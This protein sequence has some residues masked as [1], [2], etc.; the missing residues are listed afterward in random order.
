VIINNRN[1]LPVY[2]HRLDA[3]PSELL[4]GPIE[5][6]LL[7]ADQVIAN[8]AKTLAD[9]AIQD[10]T[11]REEIIN[12]RL[13]AALLRTDVD[14]VKAAASELR[15]IQDRGDRKLTMGLVEEIAVDALASHDP[16]ATAT[17]LAKIRLSLL[18]Y[19]TVDAWMK[20]ER[21]TLA[22]ANP[23][24]V[25]GQ[26]RL[27]LDP[28]AEKNGG[29]VDQRSAAAVVS[30]RAARDRLYP[31]APQ[32]AAAL[33][34][35][36]DANSTGSKT[37]IWATRQVTLDESS[38]VK[39]IT[40]AIWDSGVD[41]NLFT[42]AADPG[43]AIDGEGQAVPDLLRPT[44]GYTERLPELLDLVKGL[45]DLRAGQMTSAA[46]AYQSRAAALKPEEVKEFSEAL[47]FVANYVHGTHVAGIAAEGNPFARIQAI[48]MHFP[49]RQEDMKLD[50]TISERRAAFYREAIKRMQA[51]GARVVNMSWR[52]GP[53]IFESILA[54]Q[55]GAADANE[56]KQLAAE[57]FAIEKS[58][59]EK[60]I[61]AAPDILF[62]AGAGNEGN[63]ASFSDYIPAALSIP[64]LITVGAVDRAGREAIF[65]SVG[66]TVVIYANGV[67]IEAVVPGGQRRAFSG[68]SMAS[69][70]VANA[71]AKLAAMRPELS[72]AQL[73][74]LLIDTATAEGRVKLL[75][76]KGAF[77]KAGIEAA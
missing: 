59:L 14:A 41:M 46:A 23:N 48:S 50:R 24:L 12:H 72:G 21:A 53:E 13:A 63:D 19:D 54:T 58:A 20:A 33:A 39:P 47:G 62:V 4:T 77:E 60:S 18:P 42:P 74:Q 11:T 44:Q 2:D 45:F 38:D 32:I 36:I 15:A 29:L 10:R 56:R 5:P 31:V 52:L 26:V 68:T 37:D 35:I 30:A 76:S 8:D 51:A 67:E 71:A 70:Q 22:T 69:P 25:L 27:T 17:R 40:I 16:A 61:R 7:L 49:H 3:R 73:R 34:Q 65:T 28:I 43:M 9:F 66:G 75:N 64:N 1:E 57:L 55:G 6:V